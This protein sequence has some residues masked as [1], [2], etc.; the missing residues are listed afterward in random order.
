MAY[1]KKVKF[2]CPYCKAGFQKER[3]LR[4][5]VKSVHPEKFDE[6]KLQQ[7]R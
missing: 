6:F 1:V 2:P 3:P 7:K 4:D 5:H